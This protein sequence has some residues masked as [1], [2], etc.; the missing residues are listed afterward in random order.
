MHAGFIINVNEGGP[1]VIHDADNLTERCNTDDALNK[2]SVDYA[3]GKRLIE[4]SPAEQLERCK[5]CLR[6]IRG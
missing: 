5:H 2:Q 1:D 6:E 4:T 3:T